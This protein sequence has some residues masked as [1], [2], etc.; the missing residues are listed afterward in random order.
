MIG[1]GN[2]TSGGRIQ[3][4]D[5]PWDQVSVRVTRGCAG[6]TATNQGCALDLGDGKCTRPVIAV[7]EGT[8]T[9]RDDTQGIV[10]IRHADGWRSEYAHMAGIVVTVNQAVAEGQR[11]G[12]ISD[13][14]DPSVTNFSGCHLHFA[15]VLAN[16]EQDPWPLLRQNRGDDMEVKG[17]IYQNLNGHR[18]TT[19]NAPTNLMAVPTFVG[20]N[21]LTQAPQGA[22]FF[23]AWGVHGQATNG[24]D[25]WLFGGLHTP[26]VNVLNGY[27]H[28]SELTPIVPMAGNCAAQVLAATAPL[29]AEITSLTQQLG[30]ANTRINGAKVALG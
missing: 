16:V 23:P 6:H 1:F 17:A 27:I 18:S 3:G 5:E 4:P 30:V 15:L 14:H 24:S 10:R 25:R 11:I 26:G 22:E 7:R 8:V 28:E 9:V 21:L 2:P 29:N 13:A 20:G 12:R 19:K